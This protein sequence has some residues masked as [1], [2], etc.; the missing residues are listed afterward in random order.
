MSFVL[1]P[2]TQFSL[3]WRNIGGALK[4]QQ[5]NISVLICNSF[6][7]GENWKELERIGKFFLKEVLSPKLDFDE[8]KENVFQSKKILRV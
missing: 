1:C 7:F 8:W 6:Q 2:L 4:K 5:L 3:A